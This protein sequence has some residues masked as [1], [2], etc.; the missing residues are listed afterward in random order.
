M[1][2]LQNTAE[3]AEISLAEASVSAPDKPYAYTSPNISS[4]ALTASAIA[5]L[6]FKELLN[7]KTSGE[8]YYYVIDVAAYTQDVVVRK[9]AHDGTRIIYRDGIGFR[10]GLVAWNVKAHLSVNLG[11]IAA[12]TQLDGGST[13][14]SAHAFAGDVAMLG[15]VARVSE[16][17]GKKFDA[18]M[19]QDL[20]GFVSKLAMVV[21]KSGDKI[22]P[23]KGVARGVLNPN[24]YDPKKAIASNSYGIEQIWHQ[25][26]R[27]EL[28]Q[29]LA[30]GRFKD[31]ADNRLSPTIIAAAYAAFGNDG[32]NSPI[33]PEQTQAA[34][35]V[36]S[37]GR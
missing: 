27:S 3:D 15:D 14:V 1:W 8:V 31:W 36:Q 32:F 34:R 9:A 25:R 7:V 22:P 23:R 19:L 26:P 29:R 21:A 28:S 6:G 33:T 37:I 18:K 16:F 17:G 11:S 10:V 30:D 13:S 2:T 4:Y 20:A 12:S 35:V 24:V 5:N